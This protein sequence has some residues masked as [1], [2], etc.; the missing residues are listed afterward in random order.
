MFVASML[1]TIPTYVMSCCLLPSKFW[2]KVEKM[3]MDFLWVHGDQEKHILHYFNWNL[4]INKKLA[5]GLKTK[6]LQM[7]NLALLHK[8]A[9]ELDQGQ[10][11]MCKFPQSCLF[12]VIEFYSRGSYTAG[13]TYFQ[14]SSTCKVSYQIGN[15]MGYW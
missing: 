2:D 5:V 6:D 8:K 1:T 15:S 10:K 3:C 14:R 9:W 13:F 7:Q 4:A 12:S 11:T